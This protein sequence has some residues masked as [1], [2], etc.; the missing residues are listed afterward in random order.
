VGIDY[1]IALDCP[2]KDTLTTEGMVEMYKA[3]NRAEVIL[4]MARDKG[5]DRPASQI[6]FK[7]AINRNGRV[8]ATD[9]SVQSLLDQAAP[10]EA[11]RG[12]CA[13]CP[14][15][16][17]R[18]R[19]YG[20]YDSISYPIE[21]DTE[22]WLLSRLPDDLDSPAGYLFKSAIADFAW[23]GEQAA[24]MR[25]QGETFFK[26]RTPPVRRWPSG[27]TVS[28]D[29]V[30]H[31]M[32]HVGHLGASH[33]KMLCVFFGLI[34]LT[35]GDHIRSQQVPLE[36]PNGELMVGFLN[37]MALASSQGLDVMIDG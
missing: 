10:L 37:A 4:G 7:I 30:F 33:A 17:D 19:G 28:G 14:V 8:E 21:A 31:M 15:N 12:G 1:V 26:L 11:H 2:A 24:N 22:N 5:D 36:S 32:F 29:Q 18:D 13:S 16:R 20:C 25:S 6:T 3:R 9:V 34:E 27:L 23:S 35:E